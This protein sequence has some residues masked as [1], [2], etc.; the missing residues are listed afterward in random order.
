MDLKE[1]KKRKLLED[2]TRWEFRQVAVVSGIWSF[3]VATCPFPNLQ[4]GLGFAS[5]M[6]ALI[7]LVNVHRES[8]SD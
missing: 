2:M 3:V 8:K 7:V 4:I 5:L 1:P 6:F